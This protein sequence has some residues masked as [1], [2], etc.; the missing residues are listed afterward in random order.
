MFLHALRS[1]LPKGARV[2]WVWCGLGWG[3]KRLF[4]KLPDCWLK[5]GRRSPG[6]AGPFPPFTFTFTFFAFTKRRHCCRIVVVSEIL[7]YCTLPLYLCSRCTCVVRAVHGISHDRAYTIHTILHYR[8][9]ELHISHCSYT[10]GQVHNIIPYYTTPV[11][12]YE[13]TRHIPPDLFRSQPKS[14]SPHERLTTTVT[15]SPS[16][17]ARRWRSSQ[18]QPAVGLDLL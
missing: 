10:S 6:P 8:D 2:V 16:P 4:S 1:Q 13:T 5:L 14:H 17:P 3:R 11:S 18:A 7:M 15:L 12:P 9:T